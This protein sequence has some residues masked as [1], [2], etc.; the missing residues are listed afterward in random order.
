MAR[1]SLSKYLDSSRSMKS[2]DMMT[3]S[4]FTCPALLA[5]MSDSWCADVSEDV[6]QNVCLLSG[7]LRRKG[8]KMGE[9]VKVVRCGGLQA[10]TK[11]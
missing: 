9:E 8:K 10:V 6:K 2:Q 4:S 7:D 3:F 11:K 1:P 5:G